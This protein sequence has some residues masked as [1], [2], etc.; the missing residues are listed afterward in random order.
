MTHN[1]PLL[2][3]DTHKVLGRGRVGTVLD[4]TIA[5]A[6]ADASACRRISLVCMAFK[7]KSDGVSTS[8]GGADERV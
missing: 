1:N 3:A 8:F 5:R 6:H 2:Q 4:L 7:S